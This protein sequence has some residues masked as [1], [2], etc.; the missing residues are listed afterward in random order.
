MNNSSV[1]TLFSLNQSPQIKKEEAVS[2]V[3][4][5][6]NITRN[7]KKELNSL[8]SQLEVFKGQAERRQAVQTKI[9]ITTQKWSEKM[10]RL[11]A[12]PIGMLKVK[13]STDQGN[14]YWEFPHDR[15]HLE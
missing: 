12:T 4:H 14:F 1:V 5:L 7:T 8:N 6:L 3:P 11:G 2:L 15:L 13:I 10:K 9:N